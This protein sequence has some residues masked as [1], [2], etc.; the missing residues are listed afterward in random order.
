MAADTSELSKVDSAVGGVPSSPT[1]DKKVG[2]RRA[3]S[4]AAGVYNILDLGESSAWTLCRGDLGPR[5]LRVH[6]TASSLATLSK[7]VA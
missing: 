4:S 5:S 6:Y 2:H 7:V 3:S 1:D